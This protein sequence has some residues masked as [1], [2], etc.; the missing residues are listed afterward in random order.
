MTDSEVRVT[1]NRESAVRRLR[2]SLAGT[3]ILLAV[4]LLGAPAL[5]Q[6]PRSSVTPLESGLENPTEPALPGRNEITALREA[7][8]QNANLEESVR[9]QVD[10]EYVNALE[11]LTAIEKAEQRI[12]ALR[13]ELE[14]A[15]GEVVR[16]EKL[17]ATPP[18]PSPAE[19]QL[20]PEKVDAESAAAQLQTAQES[21]A[22]L[23]SRL[24]DLISEEKTSA[25]KHQ[26][27]AQSQMLA[28]KQLEEFLPELAKPT[29]PDEPSE[30]TAARTL[31]LRFQQRRMQRELA[32][33]EQENRTYEGTTRL[34]TL[35]RD[36][37]ELEVKRAERQV[38]EWQ[39][40]L[41]EARSI[42]ADRQARAALEA[43]ADSHDSVRKEAER[44]SELA[45][46]NSLLTE[47]LYTTQIELDTIKDSLDERVEEFQSLQE[48]A[49]AAEFSPAIGLLLRNRQSSLPDRES[50]RLRIRKRQDEISSLN[51]RLI[52]WRA[53]RKALLDMTDAVEEIVATLD[54][55]ARAL[56]GELLREW[57][58][59]I[60]NARRQLLIVL[61]ENGQAKLDLLVRLDSNEKQLL[62][63]IDS[64]AQ[65]LSEH[66]LWVRSSQFVGTQW[67]L[68]VDSTRFLTARPRWHQVGRIVSSDLRANRW[69][70]S[71]LVLIYVGLR[72][73]RYRIKRR[74]DALGQIAERGNCVSFLPTIK[75]LSLTVFIA[76][77]TP[78]FLWSL[79]WRMQLISEGEPTLQAL[80]VTL[81]G[82]AGIWSVLSMIRHVA[83]PSGLGGTHFLWPKN[84]LTTTRRLVRLLGIVLLPTASFVLFS[85][86]L[87]D[88]NIS[89]TLGRA[90]FLLLMLCM[91]FGMFR[92]VRRSSPILLHLEQRHADS[93][94]WR[95]R[96]LWTSLLLLAPITLAVLSAAG[97]HY[98]AVQLTGRVATTIGVALL[99]LLVSSLLSR[100]LL[101]TYRQLAIQRGR[102]RR[103]QLAQ[104]PSP[105]PDQPLAQETTPEL[106]LVEINVQVRK[107]LHLATGVG[108]LAAMY[109]IWIDVLPALGVLGRLSVGWEN[110]IAGEA[111]DGSTVP[112]TVAD[113]LLGILIGVLTLVAAKNLPGLMEIVVLQRLPMDAGARYA[114]TTVSKYI[115]VVT[116]ILLGFRAIGIGWSSVQ[117]LVAAVTVGLGFGLQEIFANFVSGIILL[118]ERPIRVGDTVTIGNITGTVT[119]IQIRAT[120]IVDWDNKELIVPNRAFVTG[121]L[122]NW[123]LSNPT[124]RV[125]ITV[126]IAYGS[127]TRMATKLLYE[128]AHTN[129]NVLK[130]PE[131]VVVFTEFGDSSLNFDLRLF[132]S[133]LMNYRRLKHE[134]NTKIDDLFREHG[135]EIAFPQRDLHLRS[136]SSGLSSVKGALDL[137]R[138]DS[139]LPLDQVS[140]SQ[141]TPT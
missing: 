35:Q 45:D 86:Y 81:Q 2:L 12:K 17:L 96:W 125:I 110:G 74:I 83:Q 123:T 112:V 107:L 11:H 1:R 36:M 108:L 4:E 102:E 40:R 54:S 46:F 5:G 24:Q 63:V 66:V 134:L 34:R 27:F 137:D 67:Q 59:E 114:A 69:Q 71:L 122:V 93:W 44:N 6:D 62:A 51:V 29:P 56:N 49:E 104:A 138:T 14:Q 78:A 75:T 61:A 129:I 41:A 60:L 33:L 100:W 73:A 22:R 68:L 118:F 89:A 13:L 126:G 88:E 7:A 70:W 85:E 92:L 26:Q 47:S 95:L 79:G 140:A 31:R 8:A 76:V 28:E 90:A 80:G 130:E 116:G 18:L 58:Q 15:P 132:V 52:E 119:R 57:L 38:Q 19:P 65:W 9:S 135:I 23:E 111:A 16:L 99:L 48:R 10:A 133:G 97:Y 55:D 109:A 39:Q 20:D 113:L 3:A 77:I 87:G 32:L 42:E 82:T 136:I 120:T 128:V 106:P 103:Q 43:L 64:E 21:A 121:D 53:E 37:A 127:D 91:G 72:A 98:T 141:V 101:V 105:D 84:L 50:L 115:I 124:L 30:V 117:W 94:L 131:P 139:A 25:G